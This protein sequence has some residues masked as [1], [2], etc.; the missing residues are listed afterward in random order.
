MV[1]V[2]DKQFEQLVKA[3][4]DAIPERFAKELKNVAIVIEDQPDQW[5]AKKIHL[6]HGWLLFGLYEGIPQTRRGGNYTL[7]LPDKITIFK[8]PLEHAARDEEH[9]KEMV[10]NTVWH[11]IAHHFGLG[12]KRIHEL[13]QKNHEA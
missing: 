3:G 6:R 7:V 1:E 11:E 9:L 2:S 10:K 4:I 13:E 5:Q 12:H 8:Q